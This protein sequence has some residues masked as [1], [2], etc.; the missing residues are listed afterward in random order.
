MRAEIPGFLDLSF[1]TISAYQS[2]AAM[3]HYSASEEHSD[4]IE[5]HGFYLVDSGGQYTGSTTDVTR[6]IALGDITDEMKMHFTKVAVQC[7]VW[8]M[9]SFCMDA[10]G[11]ILI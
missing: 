2:N 4:K 6:T 3:A 5:A 1:E 8:R 7:F 9:Q 11:G 10:Q